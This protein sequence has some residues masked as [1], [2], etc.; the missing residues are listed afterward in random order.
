MYKGQVLAGRPHGKGQYWAPAVRPGGAVRLVYE[1]DFCKGVREGQGTAYEH[2]GEVYTG[3]WQQNKRTGPG[4]LAYKDGSIYDGMWHADRRHGVGTFYHTSGDIFVGTFVDGKRHGL[5]TTYMPSRGKKYVAEYVNDCP[6]CGS[7]FDLG[8]DDVEPPPSQQL[9]GTI[10]AGT[11][12]QHLASQQPPSQLPV[13]QLS[14]PSKVL[15]K[16]FVAV[17][18]QRKQLK[19]GAADAAAAGDNTLPADSI[20]LLRHAFIL[21][22]GGDDTAAFVLPHQLQELMVLAGLDP[23]AAS[24]VKLLGLL[25]ERIAR[26]AGSGG[27][28]RL[29]LDEFLGVVCF[30]RQQPLEVLEHEQVQQA[31]AD[32]A[33]R[34]AA[35]AAAE[36][37]GGE[38]EQQ[39]CEEGQESW[40]EHAE[41]DDAMQPAAAAAADTSSVPAWGAAT[42][43]DMLERHIEQH[44]SRGQSAAAKPAPEP[45]LV[46]SC[47]DIADPESGAQAAAEPQQAAE[48]QAAEQQAAEQQVAESGKA[49]GSSLQVQQPE[50]PSAVDLV[51]CASSE[52]CEAADGEPQCQIEEAAPAGGA[53]AS[54]MVDDTES[55]ATATAEASAA[56]AAES[57][58]EAASSGA[59]DQMG[60]EAGDRA[61]AIPEGDTEAGP[62][63]DA[64]VEATA[65]GAASGQAV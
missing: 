25:Q 26:A 45:D 29:H 41:G 64:G 46:V 28:A 40:Q 65:A 13:L 52:A 53:A 44:R 56:S 36:E 59:A 51:G 23:A 15:A 42:D 22:A 14:Q 37:E 38:E 57:K 47:L 27:E 34:A 8:D 50:L 7:F 16:E 6:S 1:G 18:Q 2:S 20:S 55:T 21:I 61:D 62:A 60:D 33:A 63:E 9:R 49:P 3:A 12:R 11:L 4:R 48:P 43:E 17:R 31:A 19:P 54:H 39:Q 32:A 10:A 24:V 35:A 5:G 58:L 30:F